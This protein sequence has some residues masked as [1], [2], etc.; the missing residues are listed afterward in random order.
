MFRLVVTR[1][2]AKK[3]TPIVNTKT[4]INDTISS[5]KGQG[6]ASDISLIPSCVVAQE[7]GATII[8]NGDVVD[9]SG[10]ILDSLNGSHRMMRYGNI[11]IILGTSK[12]NLYGC[13]N[14]PISIF[15]PQGILRKLFL[16]SFPRKVKSVFHCLV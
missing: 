2:D 3:T 9:V 14:L 7:Q 10:A 11:D 15:C 6:M 4:C 12:N 1:D 16:V 8:I 5:Y 13:L